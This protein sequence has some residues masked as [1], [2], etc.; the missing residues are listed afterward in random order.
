MSK[1]I[2]IYCDE[3]NISGRYFSNFY[4]G[5]LVESRNLDSVN[6]QLMQRKVKLNLHGEIKWSKI[7]ENYL[8]KYIDFINLLFEL[9]ADRKIKI[10]IMFTQNRHVAQNLSPYHREHEYFLLYYQFIKHAFG[11]QYQQSAQST[12]QVRLYFDKIPDTKEK[13]A[14]F[15][16]YL[17]SLNHNKKIKNNGLIFLPEN[18]TDVHSHDHVILQSVDIILGAMQFRLNDHHKDKPEGHRTRGK[19]TIAKETVYKHINSKIREIYPGFNIGAST[20]QRGTP[21]S[22]WG[23]PYRHWLFIPADFN[24]DNERAKKNKK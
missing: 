15:K 3:S 19:R 23:D 17:L 8:N 20:S 5:A 22:R 13:A 2:I 10:R 24:L 11:F 7:T 21:T 1:E 9:I 4:G 14:Q 12:T 18:I 16:S 6:T